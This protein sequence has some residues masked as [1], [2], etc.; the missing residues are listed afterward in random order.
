LAH[1]LT[2]VLLHLLELLRRGLLVIVT[3]HHV[4]DLGRPNVTSQIDPHALFL[5]TGEVL[6]QRAPVR[7]DVIMS[8]TGPVIL[9][10]AVIQRRSRPAFA[11]NLC[12]DALVNFRRQSW[13]NENRNLRLTQHVDK[14]RSHDHSASVDGALPCG[15]T[16]ISNRRDFAIADSDISRIPRRASAVD[17]VSVR[18]DEVERRRWFFCEAQAAR[19]KKDKRNHCDEKN[20][21]PFHWFGLSF[22]LPRGSNCKRPLTP[23]QTHSN[24]SQ[25]GQ[26]EPFVSTE[27]HG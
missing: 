8:V 25:N 22:Y 23:A 16:Q 19:Q 20:Q 21:T 27:M 13:I 2:H 11:R 12:S 18:N 17:D 9:N 26:C 7:C 14:S 5:Q 24:Q 4:P 6:P 15:L 10:D 3:T 1:T